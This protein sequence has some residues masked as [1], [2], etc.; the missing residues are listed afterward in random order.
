MPLGQQSQPAAMTT[1]VALHV[2]TLLRWASVTSVS[3]HT[4]EWLLSAAAATIA[5]PHLVP[6]CSNPTSFAAATTM[7]EF[8][9]SAAHVMA[10]RQKARSVHLCHRLT[11]QVR[12]WSRVSVRCLRKACMQ[13]GST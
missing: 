2:F 1:L 12:P 6:S 4:D 5:P 11:M 7:G 8:T 3:R 9:N 10:I 13:R